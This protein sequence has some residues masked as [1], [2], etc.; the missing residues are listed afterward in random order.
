MSLLPPQFAGY[1]EEVLDVR[2]LGPKDSHVVVA[3]NSPCLKVFELQT[4]ACQILH[5]H[6]G[7]GT[8]PVPPDFTQDWIAPPCHSCSLAISSTPFSRYCPGPRCV[9]EGVALR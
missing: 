7:E 2:F 1:S 6:T 9:P 4:S 3:S 8:R 5:G